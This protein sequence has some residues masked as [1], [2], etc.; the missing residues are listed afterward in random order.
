MSLEA[1][2][3]EIKLLLDGLV[4]R[5]EHWEKKVLEIREKLLIGK[6]KHYQNDSISA[7]ASRVQDKIHL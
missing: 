2:E 3:N 1:I 6:V 7:W 4:Q 5:S